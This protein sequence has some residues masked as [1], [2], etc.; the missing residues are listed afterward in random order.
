MVSMEDI[1]AIY[2][3]EGLPD[4]ILEKICPMSEKQQFKEREVIFEEGDRADNFYLL[5]KGKILLEVEVA[6]QIIIS[7]GSIKSGYSFGWSSLIPG[8]SHTSYAVCT[9]PCEVLITPGNK[10]LELLNEDHTSGHLFMSEVMKILKNRL[11]RRTGQFLKVMTK[12]P[13]IQKLLGL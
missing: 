7:L 12:H 13:D 10:F 11:D 5:K 1:K 3:L 8:S 9:E 6:K 2:I 4:Q